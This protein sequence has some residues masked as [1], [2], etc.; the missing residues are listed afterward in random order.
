[1]MVD[2]NSTQPTDPTPPTAPAPSPSTEIGEGKTIAIIAYITWIGLVIAFVMNNEKKYPFAQFHIR[3]ML[4]LTLA[5]IALGIVAAVPILGWIVGLVGA[6]AIFVL[7]IIGLV[8]AIN[9]QSKMVPL[10]GTYA[11]EWFKGI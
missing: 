9:G 2:V 5:G 7:W 11:Q 1:M 6:I 4:L 10:L 3:Q 8:G